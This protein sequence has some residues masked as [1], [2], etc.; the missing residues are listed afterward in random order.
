MR[1]LTSSLKRKLQSRERM[2]SL[3]KLCSLQRRVRKVVIVVMAVKP[4]EAAHVQTG[5]RQR[6]REIIRT[7]GKRRIS[8]SAFIASSEGI[9]PRT[10]WA[11]N[12]AILWRLPTLQQKHQLLRLSPRQSR[13]IGW[14]L[15]AMLHP[16]IGS[17]IADTLLTSP[18]VDQCSLPTP[19][20]LQIWRRWRDTMGS[21]RLHPDM[22]V[23]DWFVNYQME[24]RKRSYPKRWCI[25]RGRSIWSH[26]LTSWAGTSKLNRCITTVST[27]TIVIASWL[28]LHLRSMGDSFWIELRNWPNTLIS[29]AAACWHLRRPRMHLPT[30]QRSGCYGTAACHTSVWKPRGSCGQWPT[31]RRWPE[32]V[33]ASVASSANWRD[34]PLLRTWLPVLLSY[35]SLC[36]R[37]YAD[38]GK[39]PLEEV[40]IWCSSLTT[41][42]GIQI[43]TYWSTSRKP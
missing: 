13:T 12:V 39:Q 2:G 26:N 25:C 41:L 10:A 38:S 42:R 24:R 22:E 28:P 34:N 32:S 14:W 31:L 30:M 43:S 18:A 5:I 3:Q 37:T 15:A 36:T 4:V 33:I 9:P 40:D 19:N 11:R 27:S 6:I 23:L 20:I 29:T 21:H 8:G 1:F 35:C 17:L 7:I 16:V